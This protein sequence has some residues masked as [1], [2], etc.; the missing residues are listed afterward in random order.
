MANPIP[1]N[2]YQRI[3]EKLKRAE[4]FAVTLKGEGGKIIAAQWSEQQE[5]QAE[6][7]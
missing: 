1:R 5:A 4:A 3:V 2:I 6:S 7:E